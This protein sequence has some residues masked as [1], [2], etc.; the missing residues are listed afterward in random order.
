MSTKITTL[1][2][3]NVKRIKAVQLTPAKN[4]LTVIGGKN[5]QGKSSVLDAISWALGGDNFK[6]SNPKRDGAYAEPYMR[7]TLDNGIVVERSG[8]NS[9][10]KVIDPSGNKG[11]QNL[12]NSFVEKL[13]LNLPKFLGQTNKE[14]AETLLKIIGVGDKL[15][16]LEVEEKSLY[17]QRTVVGRIADQKKKYAKE[18]PVYAGMPLE[19]ISASELIL[20]QQQILAKNGENQ[21]LRDQKQETEQR[22]KQAQTE[23]LK[24]KQEISR[25]ENEYVTANK[26]VAALKDEST[27]EIEKSLADIEETNKKIYA[28]LEREKAEI[29]AEKYSKQ[30][31]ELT[32]DI[33]GTRAA[34]RRLLDNANMPLE[35]L[36][37]EEGELV[38]KGQKWDC[39]SGSEQLIVATSIVR[40]LNPECGFVL[41]DKLE[42]L[43]TD[44]LQSF[45]E[46]LSGEGLQAIATRVS[47]GDECS[48][49]IEDGTSYV[50]GAN[51][52]TQKTWKEGTF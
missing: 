11:G 7:L 8:K 24:L 41:L 42:Q 52:E 46:W 9:S 22:L 21:R 12:L 39:M 25:L 51:T 14:K 38:Y 16:Q 32:A 47:T 40:K 27:A 3:E 1:E 50:N 17:D 31:D 44:T 6:P 30:Y 10:L 20:R 26:T 23:M 33:E 18:M 37:V 49:I 19:P 13:A 4:G 36:T 48:I 29:D 15:Y 45:G 2:I 34:K 43:D 28:N 5:S 35:G